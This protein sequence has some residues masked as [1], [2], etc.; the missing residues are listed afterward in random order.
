[1]R[2]LRHAATAF[3]LCLA[4]CCSL[5]AT[6]SADKYLNSNPI[7][8]D[9]LDG[10]GPAIPYPDGFLVDGQP[11]PVASLKLYIPDPETSLQPG[12]VR[13]INH[14]YPQ[15]ID[16]L[17][18]GPGGQKSIVMSDSCGFLPSSGLMLA[19]SDAATAPLPTGPCTSGT[20]KPTNNVGADTF[21]APAPPPPYTTGLSVFTGDPLNGRWEIWVVDDQV[22]D[23][24]V[25]NGGWALEFLPVTSCAGATPT[26]ARHVGSKFAEI[27]TGTEGPDVL[28]GLGSDDIIN[29]LGGGDIICGGPGKDKVRGGAGNDTLLGEG[30]RDKLVGG[31]G[32]DVCKG[33]PQRD[34][35]KTCER[36]KAI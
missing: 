8:L 3:G 12:V 26:V 7:H 1:M 30:G 36:R 17:L 23:G 22:M 32:Q 20:Y 27:I 13:G 34:K 9:A 14:A 25:I 31:G 2:R 28:M 16:V 15:D 24:G 21:P 5:A 35:A 18:V 19:L 4:L 33:G 10:E 11:G 6:A 29:G